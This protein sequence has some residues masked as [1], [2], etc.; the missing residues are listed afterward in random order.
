MNLN[1]QKARIT[2]LLLLLSSFL[3]AQQTWLKPPAA[4]TGMAGSP[5]TCSFQTTSR[6]EWVTFFVKA[7]NESEFSVLPVTTNGENQFQVVIPEEKTQSGD[8]QY[9]LIGKMAGTVHYFPLDAPATSLQIIIKKGELA[10]PVLP[11]EEKRESAAAP[12][13]TQMAVNFSGGGE[14]TLKYKDPATES[15]LN[16][17]HAMSIQLAMNKEN[18]QVN[19]QSQIAY[20]NQNFNNGDK[21]DLTQLSASIQMGAHQVELGDLNFSETEFTINS[22]GRRGIF[23]KHEGQG[24][25]WQAFTLNSQQLYGFRGFGIPKEDLGLF[26]GLLGYKSQ[27]WKLNVF[28]LSGK[29][30]PNQGNNNAFSPSYSARKG[31][32]FSFFGDLN[33]FNH[34]VSISTEAAFSSHDSNLEDAIDPENG[35]AWKIDLTGQIKSWSIHATYRNIDNKF[36]TIGQPFF[37]NDRRQ[38]G[39]NSS[40]R[41]G[42]TVS[43]GLSYQDDRS[44]SKNPNQDPLI[45]YYQT[46]LSSNQQLGSTLSIMASEKINLNLG[47]NKSWQEARQNNLL[48]PEGALERLGV[49]LGVNWIIAQGANLYLN[50]GI[51]TIHCENAPE[52]EGKSLNLQLGGLFSSGGGFSVSPGFNL[53]RQENPQS[54]EV[55]S[56]LGGTLSGRLNLFTPFISIDFMSSYNRMEMAQIS[57]NNLMLD[58]G[59]SLESSKLFKF[60]RLSISLRG[61]YTSNKYFGTTSSDYRIYL[62]GDYSIL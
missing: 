1:Q 49:T 53:V 5:L 54:G 29:D 37:T 36:N 3:S 46:I 38:Y 10:G 28:Y 52:R 26:G 61:A 59:L 9:Y 48:L 41:L 23:Y 34:Q 19:L 35:M 14:T 7:Q 40:I 2:I 25:I 47:A 31:S 55:T 6:P 22:M 56:M 58:G 4:L 15:E 16:H 30:D 20:S 24:L 42:H 51:D 39:V 45:P 62:R 50:S 11:A 18:F 60:A 32:L 43:W 8:L 27:N 33:L 21:I 17:N 12:V 13:V 44:G 57:S